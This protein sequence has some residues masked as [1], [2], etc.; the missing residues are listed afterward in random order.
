VTCRYVIDGKDEITKLLKRIEELNDEKESLRE[1]IERKDKD[2]AT[3]KS[4]LAEAESNVQ[5]EGVSCFHILKLLTI[6][7]TKWHLWTAR[8]YAMLMKITQRKILK[9]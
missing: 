7:F 8:Q 3:L 4:T 6:F 2:M 1:D 5:Q 9:H